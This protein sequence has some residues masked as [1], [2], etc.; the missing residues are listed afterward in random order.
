MKNIPLLHILLL[1]QHRN[2]MHLWGCLLA[3]LLTFHSVPVSAHYIY[4][5]KDYG[6]KGDGVQ[7]DSRAI[8][9]AIN[10]AAEQGGGV[11]SIP[12]GTYLCYSIRL[13][14]NITLR[15]DSDAV[16]KAAMPTET[17]T[18][19]LPEDN[20]SAYQDFG[21]SHWQ[22]SLIWGIGLHDVC[23]EGKGLIDGTDVLSRGRSTLNGLPVANKA[24]A[25]RDCQHVQL[26]DLK[27]LQCGH[28]A[29]LLTGVDYLTIE[30]LKIDTNRD[31]IDIDCCEHVH[32]RDCMVN[33]LNDDAIVL[34]TSYG[35]NRLKSTKDVVVERCEVSGYDVGSMLDGTYTTN[36]KLAP[37]QDGPTGRI[38]LGTESNGDF[39]DIIIRNC[40]FK[41]CR[42][43]ALETVDGSQMR[44]IRVE[45]IVMHDINNAPFYIRAGNRNR[46]PEGLKP[47]T[48]RGVHIARVVVE[49]ADSR[50]ASIIEGTTMESIR[51]VTL[52]DIRL[53]YR[54]GITLEDVAQQRGSN[55]FFL[56][57][58]RMQ[59]YPEPSAHGIQ[60]ASCF[61]ISHA[62]GVKLKNIKIE[63]LK[64]DERPKVYLKDVKGIKFKNVTGVRNLKVSTLDVKTID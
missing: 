40:R 36:V 41:H 42:G 64:T 46:G 50:Y 54:G 21:H 20:P 43:L 23:I 19:D 15:I 39:R 44:N 24:I 16:V 33:T 45:D 59:G 27:M 38:K 22:N 56:N 60:P 48:I 63:I 53:Q 51:D 30:G 10:A 7:I 1:N 37:D 32:V 2:F 34:K 14:S 29:L 61:S 25:L 3:L 8:N 9:A 52:N 57:N 28:F 58:P 62:S 13:K 5:V 35:L 4:N 49:D 47:S 6:A 55:P 31:G 26:R 17:E 12:K 18:Y 11:V